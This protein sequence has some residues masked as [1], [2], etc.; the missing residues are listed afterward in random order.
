MPVPMLSLSPLDLA[1]IGHILPI[2]P[3]YQYMPEADGC[4]TCRDGIE[5][6][7]RLSDE[8]LQQCA[9]CGTA[10]RRVIS[11][12]NVVSGQAHVLGDKHAEK[13]GFTQYRRAGKGVYEKAYG[14][15]PSIIKG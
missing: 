7:Q 4:A 10:I 2:M 14:K 3:I 5:V 13:H 12:S 8:P 15:G 9:Q 1:Q 11:P 6:L